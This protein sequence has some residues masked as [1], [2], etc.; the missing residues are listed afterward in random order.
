MAAVEKDYEKY[1]VRAREDRI[2]AEIA[3]ERE[4][5][6]G[7]EAERFIGERRL[8][9]RIDRDAKR[10]KSSIRQRKFCCVKQP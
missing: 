3:S 8:I 9:R 2:I 4:R 10:R 1:V 5:A 7:Q 6:S